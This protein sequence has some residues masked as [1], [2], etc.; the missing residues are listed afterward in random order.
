LFFVIS[1]K[2]ERPVGTFFLFFFSQNY[3]FENCG[4]RQNPA[5]L[6]CRQKVGRNF[7]RRSSSSPKIFASQIFLGIPLFRRAPHKKRQRVIALSFFFRFS[8]NYLF[9]NCGARRAFFKPYFFLS[10]IRESLVKKPAFFKAAREPSSA[11]RSA[12]EMP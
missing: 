7:L 3:L 1:T 10:F 11:T 4:A 9:E 2:K 12:R 6:F 8:R 5:F